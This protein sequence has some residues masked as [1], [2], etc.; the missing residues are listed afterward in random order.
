MR[1]TLRSRRRRAAGS[2]DQAI[3]SPAWWPARTTASARLV[4]VMIRV[5]QPR[6]PA[7]SAAMC[8][9]CSRAGLVIFAATQWRASNSRDSPGMRSSS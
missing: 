4:S 1:V 2:A 6:V 3:L 8:R 9:A 5:F 7:S